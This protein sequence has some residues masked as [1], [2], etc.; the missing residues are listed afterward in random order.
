VVITGNIGAV[1]LTDPQLNLADGATYDL[2]FAAKIRQ[3]T[4]ST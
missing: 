4:S 1:V 2:I 3:T